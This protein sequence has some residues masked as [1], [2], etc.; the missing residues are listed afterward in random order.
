[1]HLL[2]STTAANAKGAAMQSR[3]YHLVFGDEEI[4]AGYFIKV[5]E[6]GLKAQ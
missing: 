6:P 5:A 2:F 3:S 4:E 1:M